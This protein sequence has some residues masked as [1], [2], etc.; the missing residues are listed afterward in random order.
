[1]RRLRKVWEKE[2][3]KTKKIK[4]DVKGSNGIALNEAKVVF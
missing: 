3:E 1:M 4:N 2:S